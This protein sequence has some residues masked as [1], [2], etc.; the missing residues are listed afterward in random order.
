MSRLDRAI[1]IARSLVVYHAIPL[2]QRKLRRLYRVFVKAGDLAFDIGAH[3]GNRVRGLVGTG[4]RVVAVEPQPDFARIL[5]ALFGRTADVT[6][7]EAAVADRPGR[8]TLWVSERNPTLATSASAWRDARAAEPGF[9]GVRWDRPIEVETTT[10]DLLIERFGLPAFFKIDVEGGEPAV[11]AGLSHQVAT[12]SFEYLPGALEQVE[13]CGARLGAIGPYEFN[14]SPGE[15]FRLAS[16]TWLTSTEL[17]GALG[18]REA[19][20]G[21]GD[22]YARLSRPVSAPRRH[23]GLAQ[24]M[25]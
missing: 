13:A 16:Q 25:S 7:V 4:C 23:Q 18:A 9:A 19:R 21:S 6:I 22:V 11:L 17:L 10:L 12:V 20:R 3:A 24:P 1:G 15:T 14:W 5:R 8:Q 2:R